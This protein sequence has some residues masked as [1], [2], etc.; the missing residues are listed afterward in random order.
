MISTPFPTTAHR[1]HWRGATRRLGVGLV[2]VAALSIAACGGSDADDSDSTPTPTAESDSSDAGS[3][4]TPIGDGSEEA[5]IGV[6]ENGDIEFSEDFDEALDAVGCESI[7][8]IAAEQLDPSPEVSFDGNDATLT[9]SEGS[10][11]SNAWLPCGV[12]GAFVEEGQTVTVVY[13]DGQQLC[14]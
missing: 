9:F 11:D 7:I 4:A 10:V 1:A 8:N 3:D 2:T 6:D 12:M 13:P 14:E 5:P